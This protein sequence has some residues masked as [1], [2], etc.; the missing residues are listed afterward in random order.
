MTKSEIFTTIARAW[1]YT[2]PMIALAILA[3]GWVR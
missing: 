3:A 2:A 1:L